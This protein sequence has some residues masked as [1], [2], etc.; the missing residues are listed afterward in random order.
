MTSPIQYRPCYFLL[1]RVILVF[2]RFGKLAVWKGSESVQRAG[3]NIVIVS[4]APSI[5]LLHALI[6]WQF[7]APHRWVINGVRITLCYITV[8]FA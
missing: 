3:G 6:T 5:G 1:L 8:V 4:V 2:R 7:L